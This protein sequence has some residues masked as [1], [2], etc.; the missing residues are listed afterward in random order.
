MRKLDKT[1]ELKLFT[2][3]IATVRNSVG[4]PY[5][6]DIACIFEIASF[7]SNDPKHVLLPP[8][9]NI[10]VTTLMTFFAIFPF[11]SCF[12]FCKSF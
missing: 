10:G 8:V 5:L 3:S 4:I 6:K 12:A 2:S 9:V 7:R 1:Y 11:V